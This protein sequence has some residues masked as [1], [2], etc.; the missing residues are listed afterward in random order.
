MKKIMYPL[1]CALMFGASG[2]MKPGENIV[3]YQYVAAVVGLDYEY[4]F[5]P[6][7]IT[8]AGTYV[9]PTLP[10]ELLEGDAVLSSFTVNYDV[11][12]SNLYTVLTDVATAKIPQ[13]YPMP[14]TGGESAAGDFDA[15]IASMKIHDL[16]G[17]ML[18]IY[19]T[20]KSAQMQEFVYEFTWD[21]AVEEN[22]VLYLRAKEDGTGSGSEGTHDYFCAFNMSNFF[23]RF[24][25]ADNHVRFTI[26][27]LGVDADGNEAYIPYYW[28]GYSDTI[29]VTITD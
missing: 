17:N 7:L 11:Q 2:C 21:E 15:P 19:T 12:E 18:F 6:T 27:Y 24:K 14:T 23:S 26:Q 1:L 10:E 20:Q 8:S 25:D 16:V 13:G 28:Q 5:Q 3:T 4:T 9:A 22:P 29:D